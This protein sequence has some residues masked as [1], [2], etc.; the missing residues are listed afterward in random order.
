[1]NFIIIL[2]ACYCATETMIKDFCCDFVIEHV[3]IVENTET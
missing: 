2:F 1:V 3:G